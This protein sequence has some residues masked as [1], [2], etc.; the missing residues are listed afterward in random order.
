MSEIISIIPLSKENHKTYIL[1]GTQAYN[2]HYLHLWENRDPTPYLQSSFTKEVLE[3]EEMDPNTELYVIH[4]KTVPV[5]I[6]KITL[7]SALESYTKE[8]ALLVNKIYILSQHSGQGVG[9]KALEF[10]SLRAKDLNK[11]IV[12]LDTMKNGPALQFYLKNGFEICKEIKLK[13]QT[14]LEEQR[15]MYIMGKKI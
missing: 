4:R 9:K 3:K 14:V 13:F 8:E 6:V 15:P 2:Q 5:G 10:I 7:D 11:K 1:V 12:W